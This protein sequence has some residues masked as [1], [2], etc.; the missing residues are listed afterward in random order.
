MLPGS[1][2]ERGQ[3]TVEYVGLVLL[4]AAMLGAAL[5]L[6]PLPAGAARLAGLLARSLVCAVGDAP[7]CSVPED[8]LEAAY[9]AEV[10]AL[11]R[12]HAPEVRF[13]DGEY[14]SLPVDPRECRS[15]A[16]ADSSEPGRL[17]RS[18]EDQPPTAFAHVVDCREGRATTAV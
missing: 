3:A 2:C 15:R 14:V 13:E 10:A 11:L 17:R 7:G 5:A 1:R 4:L 6:V 12:R 16:C 9:G 8:D 18:F